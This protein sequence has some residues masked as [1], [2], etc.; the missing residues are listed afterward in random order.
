MDSFYGTAVAYYGCGVLIRGPSGSGKSDL[1]LRL[2]DDGGILIADDQV[3]IKF[4]GKELHLSAPNSISGLIEV[5]GVGVLKI[6]HVSGVPLSLI[7]D[8]NTKEQLQRLPAIKKEVIN[9]IH[10]SVIRINAFESSAIAKI[11]VFLQ[12][13]KNEVKLIT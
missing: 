12:Y 11:K 4:V 5:R 1:A 10:I 9:D 13:L 6:K 7:V 3:L 8:I 2:I